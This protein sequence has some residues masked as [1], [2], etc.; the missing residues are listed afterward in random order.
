V[1]EK[2]RGRIPYFLKHNQTLVTA[3]ELS[4]RAL[5]DNYRTCAATIDH[6]GG[7]LTTS[8]KRTL[9]TIVWSSPRD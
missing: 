3:G 8:G 2:S 1:G 7:C 4:Q 6:F 9:P 5:A